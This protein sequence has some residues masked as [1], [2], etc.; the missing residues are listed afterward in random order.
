MNIIGEKQRYKKF[1]RE[2][3]IILDKNVAEF[4]IERLQN[5]SIIEAAKILHYKTKYGSDFYHL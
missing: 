1:F 2:D 5:C 4:S 3:L